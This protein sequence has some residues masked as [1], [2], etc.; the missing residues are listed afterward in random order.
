[1]A[2]LAIA[3]VSF[4]SVMV[5][6][7]NR[8]RLGATIAAIAAA[9]LFGAFEPRIIDAS[10]QLHLWRHEQVLQQIVG[11]LASSDLSDDFSDWIGP[12]RSCRQV[13][14][15]EQD[16]CLTAHSLMRETRVIRAWKVHDGIKLELF[17]IL[18]NRWGFFYCTASEPDQCSA[19]NR[20]HLSKA[21]YE[22]WVE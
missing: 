5:K 8:I 6:H 14:I 20:K 4:V 15:L 7:N 17:G 18:D 19:S 22:Y 2:G 12:K 21:W 10:F 1:L 13:T 9:Y 3:F 11:L 16:D